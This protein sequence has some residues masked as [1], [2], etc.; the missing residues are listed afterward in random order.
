[1]TRY[2]TITVSTEV[3]VR[4]VLDQLDNERLKDEC[5]RRGITFETARPAR[6][7][8]RFNDAVCEAEYDVDTLIHEL[9]ESFLA[10]DARHFDVLLARCEGRYR[11]V[12][13]EA[14][15]REREAT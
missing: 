5:E 12:L 9:R 1:M 13:T 6:V 7:E 4:D 14:L 11:D 10:R 8:A 2:A 3:D 15:A